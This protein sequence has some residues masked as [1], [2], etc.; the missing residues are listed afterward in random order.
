MKN[1]DFEEKQIIAEIKK[2]RAKRVLLQL[3][4]GIKVEGPRLAR[5]IEE[6]GVLPIISGDPCYGACDITNFYEERFQID[7]IFHF[8]HTK[9]VKN[10]KIPTIYIPTK[11]TLKI[12]KAVKASLSLL[13]NYQRIGLVTTIQHIQTL[14]FAKDL[15][16]SA[17]KKVIIGT[18]NSMPF[19]GQIIGCNYSAVKSIEND[20]DAFLFI[21]G[22]RFHALGV[23]LSSNRPTVLANLFDQEA[24]LLDDQVKNLLQQHWT[25]IQ[26]AK[27]AKLFGILIS[28]KPGQEKFS[29]ALKIK[30]LIEKNEKKGILIFINE[31]IPEALIEFPTID[32]YINTA[33]PRISF[34]A[35]L[36]FIKPVLTI[37]EFKVLSG[38]CSWEDFIS[39][40]L[41]GKLN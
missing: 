8:G 9:M 39:Q 35:P 15:L 34:E 4:E 25:L 22:G 24:Y 30:K 23:A 6:L 36:K 13:K 28:L 38:D 40:G 26:K 19:P 1:F 29:V 33:C 27:K 18:S 16:L 10:E 31:I 3:P 37:N 5:L 11:S 12:D 2:H 32:A 7:L 41:F 21:G 20:V 14:E 17:G